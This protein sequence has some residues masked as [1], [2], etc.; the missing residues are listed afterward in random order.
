[1]S[2]VQSALGDALG[3]ARF[4]ALDG[5]VLEYIVGVL[6]D[7]GFEWGDSPESAMEAVG[8]LL[9]RL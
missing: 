9:V 5:A 7:D 3:P 1:M 4:A 6:E 8:G 2:A